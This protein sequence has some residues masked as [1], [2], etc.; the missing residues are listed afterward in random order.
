MSDIEIIK[1]GGFKDRNKIHK[2][3]ILGNNLYIAAG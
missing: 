2:Y 1:L 3:A